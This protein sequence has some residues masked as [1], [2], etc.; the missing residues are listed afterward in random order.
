M[1]HESTITCPICGFQKK[2]EMPTDACLFFY[3]CAGCNARLKPRPGDCCVF[4]SYGDKKCPPKTNWEKDDDKLLIPI[5]Q[6]RIL[7]E[8]DRPT[9]GKI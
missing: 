7:E 4:C 1:N 3:D 2:E 8:R 9:E 5:F 6:L